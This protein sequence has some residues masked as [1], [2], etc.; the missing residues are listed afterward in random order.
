M[1]LNRPRM[2]AGTCDSGST[3]LNL[4][5]GAING[6]VFAHIRGVAPRNEEEWLTL[7]SSGTGRIL[8]MAFC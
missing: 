4:G 8:A 5:I 2:I 3:A 1:N 7:G 6:A